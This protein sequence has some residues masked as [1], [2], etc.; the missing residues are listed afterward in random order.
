MKKLFIYPV[1][2][3][4]MMSF[5]FYKTVERTLNWM[6]ALTDSKQRVSYQLDIFSIER[7]MIRRLKF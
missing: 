2:I 3:T 5:M 6:Y 4:I 1:L 7:V